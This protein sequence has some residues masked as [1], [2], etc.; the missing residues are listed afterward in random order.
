MVGGP[1]ERLHQLTTKTVLTKALLAGCLAKWRNVR[2]LDPY[3][4]WEHYVKMFGG[5]YIDLDIK[6]P[7]SL[8]PFTTATDPDLLKEH[9]IGLLSVL[10]NGDLARPFTH[11]VN[12]AVDSV[13]ASKGTAGC[14]DDVF[15]VV[16]P[17]LKENF[18]EEDACMFSSALVPYTSDGAYGVW[19]NGKCCIKQDNQLIAVNTEEMNRWK[20]LGQLLTLRCLDELFRFNIATNTPSRSTPTIVCIEEVWSLESFFKETPSV[21][22]TL[23]ET[24]TRRARRNNA[25]ILFS[26]Q[27]I[28]D[29]ARMGVTGEVIR[30]NSAHKLYMQSH[31]YERA[32][33]EKILDLGE[34]ELELLKSVYSRCGEYSEVFVDSSQGI[35]IGRLVLPE[36]CR[37][38]YSTVP[39]EQQEL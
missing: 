9:F 1:S 7:V 4:G 2:I 28:L 29:L 39:R 37:K 33:Y 26:T 27:S 24:G 8:N 31:D 25:G 5:T 18:S 38:A 21:L 11:I 12:M 35:G 22:R 20:G 17:Y 19:L 34:L 10:I 15:A 23:L 14:F 32:N 30:N 36:S 3:R 16:H 13:W 6:Q